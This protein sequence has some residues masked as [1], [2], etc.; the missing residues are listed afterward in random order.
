MLALGGVVAWGTILESRFNSDYAKIVVYQAPWFLLILCSL[1]LN[2]LVATIMRWPFRRIHIGFV[3]THIG[4][5]TL[6]AGAMITSLYGIDGSMRIA[7]G[8]EGNQVV[9][10]DYVIE[11]TPRSARTSQ[12]VPIS[13]SI[14]PQE[15]S[16][17]SSVNEALAPGVHILRY[18]PF[19]E[20]SSGFR[21]DPANSKEVAIRF[22]IKSQFFDVQESLSSTAKPFM[23][24]GPATFR[25]RT[26]NAKADLA[27]KISSKKRPVAKTTTAPRA[28]SKTSV[29]KFSGKRRLLFKDAKSGETLAETSYDAF[30]KQGLSVRGSLFKAGRQFASATVGTG[31]VEEKADGKPNP[32][33]EIKIQ[34]G[35]ASF[36]E[37]VFERFPGFSLHPEGVEGVKVSLIGPLAESNEAPGGHGQ[38]AN[39]SGSE[40]AG[41]LPPAS[42][43]APNDAVHGSMAASSDDSSGS[44]PNPDETS[45]RNEVTFTPL[46]NSKIQVELKKD[47]KVVLSK[48][49]SPGEIIETP[50]MGMKLTLQEVVEGAVEQTDVRAVAALPRQELPPSAVLV[51]V[52]K[53]FPQLPF[54]LVE[55]EARDVRIRDRDFTIYFGRRA[56][57]LPFKLRLDKFSKVDYPGTQT[58]M[59]YESDVEI[60][61]D[62]KLT[63]IS[64][65]EPMKRDKYTLYQA[66]YQIGAGQPTAS[67]FSV[68]YDPGRFWKYL[69]SL[70][71]A[72]G[73]I[74]Y[75]LMRSR[76][77]RGT[78]GKAS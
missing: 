63:K 56:I 18:E 29:A 62:G 9:L 36:R 10:A 31:G 13:R 64:M 26:M 58:A 41:S 22:N 61:R 53:G 24:M 34:K 4:L 66:S 51:Q 25:L 49:A 27:A 59:S 7:E 46:G 52:E 35:D 57:E 17:L 8:T 5:L 23:Q 60:D 70:I 73:I 48:S 3:T 20:A 55:G 40:A 28:K 43:E 76:L 68:N 69:G 78:P 38:I 54:Y 15:E 65:N 37:I 2:I 21:A 50:W 42:G 47:G 6:L 1:F 71:A 12:V 77:G 45:S 74:T 14:N 16:S 32:A 72:I 30:I 67:I 44:A 11:L 33:L 39:A 75:T 19:V